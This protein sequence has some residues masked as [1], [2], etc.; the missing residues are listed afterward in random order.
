MLLLAPKG[1]MV[2]LKTAIMNFTKVVKWRA[3]PA[4]LLAGVIASMH[5][6]AAMSVERQNQLIKQHCAVCHT[7]ST[8]NGGLTL[9]HFDAAKADPSLAAMLLS[10]LR[11][12]AMSAAGL[13]FEKS[14]A[15]ALEM[16]MVAKSA[17]AQEWTVTREPVT[18]ASIVREVATKNPNQP[19][20]YRLLIVCDAGS[21]KSSMQ[22]SW[23]PSPRN[24]IVKASVD[25]GSP[26]SYQ[27][28]GT[29]TMG[30]G[31]AGTTGH[32]SVDAGQTI[33]ASANAY[34]K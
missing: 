25:S 3:L 23:A 7:D 34:Y 20:R 18:T 30:D 2:D 4:A 22:L 24:G 19:S 5:L 26:V 28:E 29:E 9:Q 8:Q 21:L 11:G 17:E 16:A 13:P 15:E 14:D 6:G 10:K 1:D 12:G 31:S 33:M 27:V 32:A